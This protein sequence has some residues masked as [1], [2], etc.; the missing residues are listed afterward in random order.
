MLSIILEKKGY[1]VLTAL[2]GE[3]AL[4]LLKK[5]KIDIAITDIWLPGMDGFELTS[6]IKKEYPMV[7][8]IMSAELKS[9]QDVKRASEAG[10]SKFLPKPFRPDELE[11]ILKECIGDMESKD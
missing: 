2:S 8:V 11:E 1:D 7:E 9:P 5:Q 3:D 10:V 6:R 4:D